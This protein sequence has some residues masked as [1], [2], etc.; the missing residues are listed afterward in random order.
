MLV[1]IYSNLLIIRSQVSKPGEEFGRLLK[2][3]VFLETIPR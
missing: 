3:E 1:V 2:K